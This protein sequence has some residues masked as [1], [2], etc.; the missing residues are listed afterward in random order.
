MAIITWNNLERYKYSV[1]QCSW[2]KAVLHARLHSKLGCQS[3]ADACLTTRETVDITKLDQSWLHCSNG[4][5]KLDRLED[6][7]AAFIKFSNVMSFLCKH[8]WRGIAEYFVIRSHDHVYSANTDSSV[9][10][11][12]Y[13]K[14]C[15]TSVPF[16][17]FI[18]VSKTSFVVS[19]FDTRLVGN[20][21][22]FDKLSGKLNLQILYEH[23]TN[24]TAGAWKW[25]M[26]ASSL[27]KAKPKIVSQE[28][29]MCS[30]CLFTR[31]LHSS[32]THTSP[33]S[34]TSEDFTLNLDTFVR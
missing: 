26:L 11:T 4:N 13:V 9:N 23:L 22:D 17:N 16:V 8:E 7:L 1:N 29:I 5:T 31:S 2:T 21:V 24:I 28:N 32:P 10:E 14:K 12:L 6:E 3:W 20:I 34:V 18:L 27:D 15:V 25:Y 33:K 30:K 19:L